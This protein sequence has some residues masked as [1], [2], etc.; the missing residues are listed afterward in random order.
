MLIY[1]LA[2]QSITMYEIRAEKTAVR[3]RYEEQVSYLTHCHVKS[4]NLALTEMEVEKALIMADT[5][6]KLAECDDVFRSE[7]RDWKITEAGLLQQLDDV[8][9]RIRNLAVFMPL[10]GMTCMTTDQLIELFHQYDVVS[11]EEALRR[12][13]VDGRVFLDCNN[14]AYAQHFLH[15]AAYGDAYRVNEYVSAMLRGEL[16][17][18]RIPIEPGSDDPTNWAVDDVVAFLTVRFHISLS[19]ITH[20]RPVCGTRGAW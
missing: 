19:S 1:V 20:I 12:E 8:N 10:Y 11:N 4:R 6:R 9:K 17:P 14:V 2:V 3:K 16:V 15:V 18:Q 5:A 7:M 13:G